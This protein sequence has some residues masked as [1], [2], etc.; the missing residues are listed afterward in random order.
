MSLTDSATIA[1]LYT[2]GTFAFLENAFKFD[3]DGSLISPTEV[4][5]YKTTTDNESL[6]MV[7]RL[8][9]DSSADCYQNKDNEG[10]TLS[11]FF[12]DPNLIDAAGVWTEITGA[13]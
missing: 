12:E 1:A 5:L 7:D 13:E 8:T 2:D 3:S 10:N 9:A 4:W 6:M 11:L